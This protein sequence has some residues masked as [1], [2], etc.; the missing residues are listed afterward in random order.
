MFLEFLYKDF[1]FANHLMKFE[2]RGAQVRVLECIPIWSL[3]AYV[4]LA[5]SLRRWIEC[6]RTEE[7]YD[8]YPKVLMNSD[9]EEIRKLVK[10]QL[11]MRSG[12]RDLFILLIRGSHWKLCLYLKA[13][14]MSRKDQLPL[15]AINLLWLIV[16]SPHWPF[17]HLQT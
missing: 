13:I 9:S 15:Y 5:V 10:M 16:N 1:L 7:A 17:K 12:E 11:Q 3:L 14:K 6:L 8:G 2:G 4:Y